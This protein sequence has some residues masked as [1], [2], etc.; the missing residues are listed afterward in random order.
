[1]KLPRLAPHDKQAAAAGT[2]CVL[3][4]VYA[5]F[6]TDPVL[7]TYPEGQSQEL[8]QHPLVRNLLKVAESGVHV[9]A[10]VDRV[11]EDTLLVEIPAAQPQRMRITSAWKEDMA[12]PLT[13]AGFLRRAHANHPTAAVVLSLEGHGAGFL[14]EIDRTQM[15]ARNITDGG[16]IEGATIR[17]SR[18]LDGAQSFVS[19]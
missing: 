9:A 17:Q 4:C 5:P 18:G 10:L 7:S 15:S 3:L 14:P 16:R 1:M 19:T 2:D 13:L 11:G 12:S 6:G 8:A